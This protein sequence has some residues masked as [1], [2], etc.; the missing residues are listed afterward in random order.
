MRLLRGDSELTRKK[1][2]CLFGIQPGE[3]GGTACGL[4]AP[5]KTKGRGLNEITGHN[6]QRR[7]KIKSTARQRA[8]R[9][10]IH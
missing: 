9:T 4:H 1:G 7:T 10:D 5:P 6:P 8:E 3:S 2:G